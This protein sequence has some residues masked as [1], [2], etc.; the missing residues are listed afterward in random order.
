MFNVRSAV[1]ASRDEDRDH[2]SVHSL[3]P[4]TSSEK[5]DAKK[6][7][8]CRDEM[9]ADYL[10][11]RAV[12][13]YNSVY[14]LHILRRPRPNIRCLLERQTNKRRSQG[15]NWTKRLYCAVPG[16]RRRPGRPNCKS[17]V[18]KD[19]QRLGFHAWEETEPSTDKKASEGGQ[20][21][22]MDA[23]WIN[24]KVEELHKKKDIY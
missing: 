12:S 24:V 2:D 21:V 7:P 3:L 18:E 9:M 5:L 10:S 15:E 16:F 19:P 13:Q 1:Y 8:R 14:S 23:D 4:V 11:L 20:C 6:T 22:H 17:A